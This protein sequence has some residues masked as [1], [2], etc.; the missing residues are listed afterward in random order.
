MGESRKKEILISDDKHRTVTQT[1]W[2][3][4]ARYHENGQVEIRLN[5]DL[6]PHI[7]GFKK[8]LYATFI[9]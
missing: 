3:Q 4:S 7:L 9:D 6:A 8:P 1:F 2:V 5:E